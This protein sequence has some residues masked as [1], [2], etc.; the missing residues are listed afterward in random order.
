MSIKILVNGIAGSGKTSLIESFGN[1]TFVVSRDAK[2]FMFPIPHMM[3]DKW[4]DMTTFLYGADTGQ[5]DDAGNKIRIEGVAD[6]ITLY[7]QKMGKP[8]E[9]V[10]IDSGS[11]IWM[12]VIEKASLT[13]N[14]YGSQGAEVTKEM[15]IFTKFIHEYLELNGVNV[16]LLNHVI[17]EKVEGAFTGTYLPFGTGKFKDKGGFYSTV[18]ESVTVALEGENRFV[19][20][21]S[22]AKMA[23][24]TL[25]D[26]PTKMYVKNI[27]NPDKSKKLKEGEKYFSLKDHLEKLKASRVNIAEFQL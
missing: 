9:N 25:K 23:R 6:K 4:Y 18:N 5:V 1:E 19:Y 7:T 24:T 3:V 16:I 20:T 15:G 22:V 12:D 13:P 17:E 2:N 27:V 14:V 21:N 26:L 11:Q 10:V 8:P